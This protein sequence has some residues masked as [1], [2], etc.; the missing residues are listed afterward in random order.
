MESFE[1]FGEAGPLVYKGLVRVRAFGIFGDPNDLALMLVVVLP[2]LFSKFF[3][4]GAAL[5]SRVLSLCAAVL[6]IYCIFLTNSRGGWLALG[7]MGVAYI[8]LHLPYK[9][10]GAVFAV[11][12]FL[13]IM[14]VGPSRMGTMSVTGGAG[15]GRVVSWGYGNWML[16]RW[17]MFGAGK[18]RFMEFTDMGSTGHSS[19]VHCWSE[20]GLFGY[21][22]W[23][24]M[25]LASLKDGQ[26]LSKSA[27]EDPEAQELSR[28]AK[29]AIAS[30]VGFMSAGFF[31]SRTYVVPLYIIFG[32]LAAMRAT[33]ELKF[34]RLKSA[35]VRRD[36]RL[37]LAVEMV[38]IVGIYVLMRV[39]N[40][41][42]G[43]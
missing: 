17:P 20:L 5:P 3:Q 41:F 27:S 11:L 31:L 26:A 25:V 33:Y 1:G 14:A 39:M 22:F 18:G 28:L 15:R 40:I 35:F 29:A 30:F 37:V 19:F 34:G 12:A 13:A 43:G 6:I 36:W 16:K 9:K 24:G 2:F 4:R 32:L 7:A 23:L 10:I 38:S 21:F 42:Y 8:Y